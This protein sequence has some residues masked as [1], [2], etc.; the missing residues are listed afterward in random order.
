MRS[1]LETTTR[2]RGERRRRRR[3]RCGDLVIAAIIR[4]RHGRRLG[5]THARRRK[6]GGDS[7]CYYCLC[8]WFHRRRFRRCFRCCRYRRCCC[9]CYCRCCCCWCRSCCCC[10]CCRC[11]YVFLV[12]PRRYTR[13]GSGR[14]RARGQTRSGWRWTRWQQCGCSSRALV[15]VTAVVAPRR[16]GRLGRSP[17]FRDLIIE[18]DGHSSLCRMR[19]AP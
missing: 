11:D 1:L 12:A 7:C 15:V 19:D 14:G 13:P 8:R 9:C 16:H 3:G 10:R 18:L 6:T 2:G 4:P 5:R 17:N